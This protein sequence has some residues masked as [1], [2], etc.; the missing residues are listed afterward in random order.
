GFEQ[1]GQRLGQHLGTRAAQ[2]VDRVAGKIDQ[3]AF[4]VGGPYPS[5][6]G[7]FE[8]VEHLQAPRAVVRPDDGGPAPRAS[9]LRAG[10]GTRQPLENAP[11]SHCPPIRA[12]P[13]VRPRYMER[14]WFILT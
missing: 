12:H 7:P 14:V 6:A 9:V 11:Y 5:D 4:L 1:G 10:A 3:A 8:L 13:T 2:L